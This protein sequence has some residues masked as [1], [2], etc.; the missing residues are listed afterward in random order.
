V[1]LA[2]RDEEWSVAEGVGSMLAQEYLG[3]VEVIASNDLSADRTGEILGPLDLLTRLP[4]QILGGPRR[5]G[6]MLRFT[7][8]AIAS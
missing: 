7:L 6:G 8:S 2:A 1:V 3:E 5:R 4:S